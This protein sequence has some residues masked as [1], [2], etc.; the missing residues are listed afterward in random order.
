MV[1]VRF[2]S[3]ATTAGLSISP[4]VDYLMEADAVRSIH[5][6]TDYLSKWHNTRSFDPS[7]DWNSKR[8]LIIRNGGFGDLIML[9]PLL[10]EFRRRWSDVALVVCCGKSY[11]AV[12]QGNPHLSSIVEY[13]L[14][15]A[16]LNVY[17]AV[18]EFEETDVYRRVADNMNMIDVYGAVTGLQISNPKPIIVIPDDEIVKAR[19][20][21][22]RTR[23]VARIG[24]Q[25]FASNRIRT[26]PAHLLAQVV[27][28]LLDMGYEVI[29]FG[30]I[31]AE[32]VARKRLRILSI[33]DPDVT[34]M[35]RLAI[36]CTCDFCIAPDSSFSH[37]A[38]ALGI[39]AI[40][41]YGPIPS[42]LR[43]SYYPT[44]LAIDGSASCAPCFH[45]TRGGIEFPQGAPCESSHRCEALAQISPSTILK[46]VSSHFARIGDSAHV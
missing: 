31:N 29:L 2:S 42:H 7:R 25:A 45:H 38:G 37:V 30:E 32:L 20:I 14:K 27:N 17:D 35:E 16:D 11:R 23:N 40:V 33:S 6:T 36:L 21:F 26:Y 46:A 22:P 28:S 39:P 24:I 34:F 44:V 13:P 12:L 3:I 18:I 5:G 4:Y 15:T 1:N 41:C 43:S 8:V 19:R 10:K 9:T